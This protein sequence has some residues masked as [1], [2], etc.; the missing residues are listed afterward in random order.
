MQSLLDDFIGI[1]YKGEDR[2]LSDMIYSYKEQRDYP[3]NIQ[4]VLLAHTHYKA[5]LETLPLTSQEVEKLQSMKLDVDK[6]TYIDKKPKKKM[7]LTIFERELLLFRTKAKEIIDIQDAVVDIDIK[8]STISATTSKIET[9][10]LNQNKFRFRILVPLMTSKGKVIKR[11][12][13]GGKFCEYHMGCQNE[14]IRK[15]WVSILQIL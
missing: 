6:M 11:I 14:E 4:K 3:P 10:Y 2:V 8:S 1:V 9:K 15:E 12:A 13:D 5:I 7:L